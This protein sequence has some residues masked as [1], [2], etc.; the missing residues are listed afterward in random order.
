MLSL[1]RIS[2]SVI[3][4]TDIETS[5][6]PLLTVSLIS[7]F[8][9]QGTPERVAERGEGYTA[10]FLREYMEEIESNKS[11]GELRHAG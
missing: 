3:F 8:V 10:H 11:K 5:I 6:L 2:Y 1:T 4:S 9:A 7:D